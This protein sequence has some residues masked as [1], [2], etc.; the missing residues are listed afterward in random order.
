MIDAI[1]AGASLEEVQQ[2]ASRERNSKTENRIA[3]YM[4]EKNASR[5]AVVAL[6]HSFLKRR[7]ECRDRKLKSEIAGS[8][9]K[10]TLTY[11]LTDICEDF[12]EFGVEVVTMVREVDGWKVAE[13][14]SNE[15]Y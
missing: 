1:E 13:V 6:M 10:I 5:E 8:D 12:G 14:V 7:E 3:E 11:T 4:V 2:F 15:S 9:G